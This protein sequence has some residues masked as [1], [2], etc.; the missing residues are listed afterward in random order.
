LC[1]VA[2]DITGRRK[3][4]EELGKYRGRLEELVDER[5][6]E[7][8]NVN[9]L[10]MQEIE[11]RERAEEALKLFAY[12][13]VHDLKS[14]AIGIHGLSHLLSRKYGSLLDETGKCYCDNLV[15]TSEHIAALV[16]K[17][18]DYI[19]TKVNRP[20]F[21]EMN[22]REV[23]QVLRDEFSMEFETRQIYWSAPA[24]D[25]LIRADRLAFQRVFRNLID[26]SL[27]YGGDGL[28]KISV[29][30]GESDDFHIFAV[31]DDGRGIKKENCEKIFDPFQRHETSRGIKGAGLGLT[32]IKEIAEQ[33]GGKVWAD[34]DPPRGITFY[35]S[36][37]KDLKDFQ[38]PGKANKKTPS[39]L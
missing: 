25:K 26:N 28:S 36:I 3:V 5:T 4:E 35:I 29:G 23:L 33:H 7:L 15:R 6:A 13:I 31:A 10:L 21:E 34:P 18:N 37:R 9:N 24:G 20:V 39:R 32:I 30:Y 14:P 17:I 27:K 19:V 1:G 12:S 8:A 11:E 38:A 22:F 16:D 2:R